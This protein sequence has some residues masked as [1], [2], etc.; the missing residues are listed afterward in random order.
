[1]AVL[2]LIKL[3]YSLYHAVVHLIKPLLAL[4]AE[5]K[6]KTDGDLFTG[7]RVWAIVVDWKRLSK[8]ESSVGNSEDGPIVLKHSLFKGRGPAVTFF[9]TT[10]YPPRVELIS[11]EMERFGNVLD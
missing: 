9:A 8:L 3:F 7:R 11:G 4:G 2:L 10:L 1:V 6:V 5:D